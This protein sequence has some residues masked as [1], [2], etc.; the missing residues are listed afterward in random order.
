[1]KSLLLS[2][3]FVLATCRLEQEYGPIDINI[4]NFYDRVTDAT[5]TEMR[6]G[7]WFLKFYA[8]WCGHCKAMNET[9]I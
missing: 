2:L 3:F 6:K 1:M 7:P 8:P 9:W 4:Y 5:G